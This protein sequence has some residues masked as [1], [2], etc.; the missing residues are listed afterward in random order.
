MVGQ[1]TICSQ[2]YN[3]WCI[4]VTAGE[5]KQFPLPP[6]CCWCTDTLQL[7]HDDCIT[8]VDTP[9]SVY[10]WS[11]G[12]HWTILKWGCFSGCISRCSHGSSCSWFLSTWKL[13]LK[14]LEQRI[15]RN[16]SYTKFK[17][18]KVPKQLT[19]VVSLFWGSQQLHNIHKLLSPPN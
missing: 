6:L 14:F 10:L 18:L 5:N 19:R 17:L 4:H 13:S 15:I 2:H 1:E 16:P 7:L 12:R 9:C 3:H 8:Y 11:T